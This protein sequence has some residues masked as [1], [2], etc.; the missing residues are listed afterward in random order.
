MTE[1]QAKKLFEKYN[2][3]DSVVRCPNGRAKMRKPLD[4]YARAAVNLYGIIRRD[5]FVEIFNS[6][7][8]E[9]TSVDEVFMILLPNV[10]KPSR[11]YG[12]YKDYIVHY[13]VLSNFDWVD[14]LEKNQSDKPRYIPQKKEF[15][16]Y[17]WEWYVDHDHWKNFSDFMLDS[18]GCHTDIYKACSE[19]EISVT[20][21]HSLNKLGEIMEEHNLVFKDEKH[22]QKFY[23][24][25][26]TVMNNTRIWENKGHTPEEL[27]KIQASNP[28]KEPVL[29]Q[30][31][32]A[33]PNQK[34]PCGSGKNISIAAN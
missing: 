15:L 24:A 6:Q 26:M 4:L 17:E 22:I 2:P 12:F 16:E 1:K 11:W 18:F 20:Q 21:T 7:N 33:E 29:Q 8:D 23:D 19:I 32:K 10:L 5:E 14:H 3:A 30:R 31:I 34:C 25:I 9:Q 27:M 28:P 13:A